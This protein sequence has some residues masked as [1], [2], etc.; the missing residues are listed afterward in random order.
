MT[1]VRAPLFALVAAMTLALAACGGGGSPSSSDRAEVRVFAA[2][3]LTD[4][5]SEAGKRFESAHPGARVSFSFG[6]SATLAAQINEGAPADVFAS[7]NTAQ[8]AAAEKTGA[9]RDPRVFATN[10]LVVVTARQSSVESYRDLANPAIRLVLAAKDVPAG[11]YARESLVK[12]STPAGYGED[13]ARRVL[14]NLKSEE[15][16][17][18]AALAKVELGEADAAIVYATDVGAAR[19]ARAL[20]IPEEFNIE[21]RYP[22]AVLRDA[23]G[24]GAAESFV[25]FLLSPAGQ[26]VLGEFGFGPGE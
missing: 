3:S 12:A 16:N 21:A 26:A 9:A 4:A 25:Q 2:A 13:F 15:V 5:F 19:K 17:V 24:A 10:R 6:S 23:K 20:S 14:A 22:I 7:A 11:Q 1:F 8:M 18:R